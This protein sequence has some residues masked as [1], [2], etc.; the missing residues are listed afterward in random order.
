MASVT[1]RDEGGRRG[2]RVRFYC[3]KRRREIYLPGSGRAAERTAERVAGYCDS[4]ARSKAN[5]VPP[6]PEAEA[7]ANGTDGRLRESLVGWGLA[8]PVS[9]RLA[10]DAG[11]FLGPFLGA[12][13]EGRTDVK[14]RTTINYKQARRL[15]CEYFGEQ[16]L[17]REITPADAERWRR[18][19]LA[20][21]VREKSAS[22]PAE[23]MAVATV[24]K[25]V[26]RA[27]T[28]FAEAVRDRLL[29]DSPF[30]G[31]KGGNESNSERHRFITP[32]ISARVLDACPDADWRV[33]FT[34]ARYG[35]MR[36]PSEILPLR[37]SDIDWDAGRLRINSPKT[38]L[39]FCP[40][41]PEIR[42]ALGEA[43]DLAEPGSVFC[44]A[45]Y[46]KSSN[47]RTQF[48]RILER[49]G[50]VPWPKLFVNLRSTRR[51]ELQ[52][53]FPSHVVDSWLGHSS[54]VAA[55]HYLQVT[56]EHWRR[57]ADPG[58]PIPGPDVQK[59]GETDDSG[60]PIGAP[61]AGNPG[62]S[63]AI[64]DDK[65]PCENRGFDGLRWVQTGG[66]VPP[67]GLEPWTH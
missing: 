8:D 26:K 37:W 27:R 45:G 23:T 22:A 35:G 1:K 60:A 58:A 4:L 9:P 5:N 17:L 28:M 57:A 10:T 55:K 46:R 24:S 40:M 39:R 33:I 66:P 42:K 51:T 49:A 29:P 14:P 18:W 50:V 62:P 3:D 31:V 64:T 19:L 6:D 52:E 61:I 38:G 67:Q 47:L 44:V 30:A 11:R 43:F 59:H 21:V 7:W 13:I 32:E 34:L 25:H 36:C 65:K 12:Y 53:R 56:D 63:R 15:L 54:A 48:G 16:H 20:R 41:F 2:F